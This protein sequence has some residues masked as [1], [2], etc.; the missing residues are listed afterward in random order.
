MPD[1]HEFEDNF[2]EDNLRDLI[3]RRQVVAV[4]GS[5]VSLATNPQAPTWRALIE[6]AVERCGTLGAGDAWCQTIASQL[7]LTSDADML[8]TAAEL[9]HGKLLKYGELAGWLRETF[10][11]LKPVD[12]TVIQALAALDTP[13]VT[14]NYD[15]LIEDV[16]TLKH[17]TWHDTRHAARVVRG[18]DR[19]VLHLHG[20]WD[21][22]D[23]VVLGIRSYEA[24]LNHDYIQ[25]AMKAFGLTKSFLFIGCGDEGLA[26]PNFGNFL[27]WLRAL[28]TA[29]GV[30]HRHYRL[31]RRCEK[32]EQFGRVFPLVYGDDYPELPAFLQRLCPPPPD[33][34][35]G[36]KQDKTLIPTLA[37]LPETVTAYLTR[38]A[39]ETSRLKLLGMG[40]SLQIELPIDDAYVPLRTTLARSLEQRDTERFK[41]HHAECEE[42][43][44]L[45]AV[46]HQATRLGQRG[47]VLLGEPGSGKTTGARQIAWRLASR[48]CLSKDLGLPA[49]ITPVLLRFRNLSRAALAEKHGLR[50]FLSDE[51]H[52]AAAPDGLAAPGDD[53]WNGRGGGLLWILDG[54]DEVIDPAARHT[55][56]RWVQDALTGRSQDRFLVT[57]RFAG[58]FRDGVPLGSSFV[59]FHVRP[60]DDGQIE[61]FVRDWFGAAYRKLLHPPALAETRADKLLEVLARPTYQ[62]GHIRELCTNPLLLTILCIVFHDEQTLPTNRA[63]LF[64][65]CVRVLLQHWRRDLYESELGRG[66]QTFDA[67]AAQAVLA[68]LAWWMHGEQNRTA[69]PLD[70]LAAEAE[71]GLAEVAASSGLGRDGRAFVERMKDE[72][73]VLAGEGDGRCGFLHL[74]FQEYLAADY[75]AREGLAKELAS[76]AADS[77]WREVALLSLRHSR[78]FCEAFFRELLAAGIAEDHPDLADRCLAEALFF[79]AA[80]FTET[81]KLAVPPRRLAAVLRL[82][83]D[84][85]DQVPELPEIARRLAVADDR[86][87]QGYAREILARLKI[88]LP[89]ATD[90]RKV[91]RDDRTGITFVEIPAGEFHMGSNRGDSDEKPIHTVRISQAFW[92]GRYPVT[93]AQYAAFMKAA[94]SSVNK[95]ENW[96]DRRFNQPEQPVVG[97]S[98][99][100]ARVFCKWAGGR[101]PTEAEWEYACR[102]GT[103]TEYSFGDDEALLGEYA[104]FDGNSGRQTQ[105][106]GTKRP[107]G[108]GLHDMHGNVREWCE[109]VWHGNYE[110]APNDG[111]AWAAGGSGR[112]CRGGGWLDG[113][114]YCRSAFRNYWDPGDRNHYLGFR[115]VLA[116]SVKEDI[117]PFS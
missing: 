90:E 4:V 18:E 70:E 74:S 13:L 43:V 25:A 57:C 36:H 22:P 32:V 94:G 112:V 106:V 49:G 33:E 1:H 93:N 26:D 66:V 98:W 31:V 62:T 75:A 29:G 108:W 9:V 46:F 71:R 105:P 5:G 27:A 63:E 72:T 34:A 17:V 69:A 12:G 48:Q 82:L 10:E 107:N 42:D 103:T 38:L 68:R 51:T 39:D 100:E 54:L 24:V 117:R 91:I 50:T 78:P 53:L 115:L 44:E 21:E 23:S 64:A 8:L 99:D 76:W 56:S 84:R 47:V 16:T 60:L 116:A 52:C 83:R 37:A 101:L 30:E 58:Y 87:T 61:R 92:L 14:T 6:S 80:P 55:V 88:T 15:D 11:H 111:R 41:E 96:D 81:L 19:R 102:A 65:I 20:H 2:F 73:G 113:A 3:K 28:E 104:W 67:E 85:A 95:P 45:G 35:G 86:E 79:S 77:W 110:G 40:R 7:A 59:E 89:P 109:D 114:R 97:V